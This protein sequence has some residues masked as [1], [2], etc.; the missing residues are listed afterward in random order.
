MAV[1]GPSGTPDLVVM[2]R[3]GAY[4]DMQTSTPVDTVL[5]DSAIAFRITSRRLSRIRWLAEDERGLLIGTGSSEFIIVPA[6]TNEALTSRNIRRRVSTSRGSPPMEPV[7]VDRQVL[8]VQAAR[9]TL[10]E[11]AYVFES[12]GYKSPSMS[13]FAAH[14]GAPKFAQMAFAAEPHS[15]IWF[16]CDDGSIKGL[17]YNRDEDVVG[18]HRHDFGGVVESICVIP[19]PT[20]QVDVLWIVILRTINGVPR[21]FIER[22]TR[23]WDFDMNL[24][25]H[26]HFVDAGLRYVGAPTDKLYGLPHLEGATVDALVD[27]VKCRGLVVTN[28]MVELPVVGSGVT[29][30][31]VIG[32]PFLSFGETAR[33]EAGAGDGTA[34]GKTK[35]IHNCFVHVWE[36]YGGEFGVLHEEKKEYEYNPIEYAETFDTLEDAPKLQTDMFKVEM[37]LGYDKR[38]A[39]AF[40]QE[41]PYP[42]NVV[43]IMPQLNTQDR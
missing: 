39:L 5:D 38:G 1:G 21:R 12:D 36:S 8:F 11:F 25:D 17:T 30:Q 13:L 35:R 24:L 37:P 43:S 3:T 2:S 29:S 10:R 16:R 15:I 26:A 33:I 7:K 6:D 27:G 19:S 18:W 4:E 41:D 14:M 34:Q 20:E 22:L 9:K 42:L 28:G 32:L 31:I 40:R 23:F